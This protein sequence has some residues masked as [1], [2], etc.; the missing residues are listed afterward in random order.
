MGL[1]LCRFVVVLALLLN[2]GSNIAFANCRDRVAE[3]ILSDEYLIK[4]TDGQSLGRKLPVLNRDALE[5]FRN[6]R[7]KLD[8][9]ARDVVKPKES[10]IEVPSDQEL[11]ALI[12]QHMKLFESWKKR[13]LSKEE[14]ELV[15]LVAQLE[16]LFQD[17]YRLDSRLSAV[18]FK[19]MQA[20]YGAD[21]DL[22]LV[23]LAHTVAGFAVPTKSN[24]FVGEA[25]ILDDGSVVFGINYELGLGELTETIHG[26]QSIFM[27]AASLGRWVKKL[28]L[29]A[30]PCGFCRQFMNEGYKSDEFQ[31]SMSGARAGIPFP[32]FL[33]LDFGPHHL[34]LESR[35]F[36]NHPRINL[37]WAGATR[38][39]GEAFDLAFRAAEQSYSPYT[40]SPAGIAIEVENLDGSTSIYT[41]YYAENVAFNPSITPLLMA[42]N[43]L[44]G[45]EMEWEFDPVR[46]RVMVHKILSRIKRVSLVQREP[47]DLLDFETSNRPD[48][49]G[50]SQL[51]FQN[52][53]LS[54]VPIGVRYI[55]FAD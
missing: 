23:A 8:P 21:E 29:P 47:K 16:P 30:A 38:P 39:S 20:I 41:G 35:A 48:F 5:D 55:E 3:L 49:E 10:K 31:I 46:K 11:Q 14:L 28:A 17:G 40:K 53:G 51:F 7:S 52:L 18:E 54:R 36:L 37:D 15:D 27:R 1:R 43:D 42:I 6:F 24:Y 9:F 13:G 25:A 26:E 44:L 33:P 50:G 34:G 4:V 12:D 2:F 45:R 19:Q 32:V 22:L